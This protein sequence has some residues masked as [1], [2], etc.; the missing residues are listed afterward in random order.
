MSIS[1]PDPDLSLV[2]TKQVRGRGRV[3]IRKQQNC[4]DTFQNSVLLE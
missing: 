1:G 4:I 2:G 3:R